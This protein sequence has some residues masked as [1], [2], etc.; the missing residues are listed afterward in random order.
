MLDFSPWPAGRRMIVGALFCALWSFSGLAQSPRPVMI[1][2]HADQST[3]VYKPI[4]TFFGA[5]EPNCIYA[6]NGQKLLGELS[7][8]SPVPVYFRPHNL[9]TT[10]DGEGSLKW[11]S[12]NAYTEKPDGSPVYDWTITDRIYDALMAAH[13]RRNRRRR[14]Y[15]RTAWSGWTRRIRYGLGQG[16]HRSRWICVGRG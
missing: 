1:A 6:P 4:W 5:D 2:V 16:P 12:T 7:A 8:L 14:C 11:G 10:G 3:G 13:V 15:P 9:L